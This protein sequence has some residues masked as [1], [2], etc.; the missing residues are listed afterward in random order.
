MGEERQTVLRLSLVLDGVGRMRWVLVILL[1][2]C[3]MTLILI[4][5]REVWIWRRV[6]Y[7]NNFCELK[8]DLCEDR[9]GRTEFV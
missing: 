1:V 7:T 5:V 3:A 2:V 6:E 4:L 8:R 9:E